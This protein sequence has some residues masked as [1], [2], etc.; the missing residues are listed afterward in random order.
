LYDGTNAVVSQIDTADTRGRSQYFCFNNNNNNN[1][2]NKL[3]ESSKT[4]TESLAVSHSCNTA[5][6]ELTSK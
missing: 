6:Q 2:N 1:N 5:S 4:V 3:I